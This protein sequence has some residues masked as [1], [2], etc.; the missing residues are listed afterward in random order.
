MFKY[1]SAHDLDVFFHTWDEVEPSELDDIT[2]AY[3]PRLHIIQNRPLFIEEKQ[4]LAQL[5]PVSPPFTIFDMAHSVAASLALAFKAHDERRSYDLICRS[6]FDVI[7]DG[8]WSGALPPAGGVSIQSDQHELDVGFNDQFAIGDVEAMRDYAGFAPWLPNGMQDLQGPVFRPEVALQHYWQTVCGRPMLRERLS[9]VLLREEQVGR[10]F[11]DLRDDPM[12]HARKREDWEAFATSHLAQEVAGRLNF[13]HFGRTP[14]MLDRWLEALPAD[15]RN[16]VLSLAWPQ[17]ILAIDRLVG[18]EIGPKPMD[19]ADYNLVRLICAALVHRMRRD[20]PMT[21][22]SF[23][24]HALSANFLDMRRAQQ[25]IEEDM[26]RS[27]QV[28]A[29]LQGA[30]TLEAALKFAPPFE[31]PPTMGWRVD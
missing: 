24:V 1:F 26:K 7:Y 12:F 27:E 2:T 17:R 18:S 29:A 3:A 30:P 11:A 20:E 8:L 28:A 16:V 13:E 25:W 15:R 22:E 9:F 4:K 19:P 5:F 10:P 31:Q 23:V 14:L 6:R 21:V